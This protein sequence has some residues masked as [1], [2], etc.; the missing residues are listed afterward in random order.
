M[1]LWVHIL[2]F[3]CGAR[4]FTNLVRWNMYGWGTRQRGGSSSLEMN[5]IYIEENTQRHSEVRNE[6]WTFSCNTGSKGCLSAS[7]YEGANRVGNRKMRD[8]RTG[9][10]WITR[11]ISY[12]IWV[13]EKKMN[14][15]TRKP[16]KGRWERTGNRRGMQ[17]RGDNLWTR[18][19]KR[20]GLLSPVSRKFQEEI[21]ERWP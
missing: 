16:R 18:I 1:L 6:L 20:P 15:T 3:T 9:G 8:R 13:S 17:A 12:H 2:L 14:H 7:R 19:K 10:G 21:K 11:V 5:L 4:T